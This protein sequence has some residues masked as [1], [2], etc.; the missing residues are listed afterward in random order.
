LRQADSNDLRDPTPVPDIFIHKKG[1][2]KMVDTKFYKC[3]HCGN[4]FGTIHDA[5]VVPICCGEKMEILVPN[6]T[7]AAQEKHVPVV[8]KNGNSVTV[9]VG[10]V[11][12]PMLAEHSIQWIIL[13]SGNATHRAVLSPGDAPEAVFTIADA[14]A[15]IKVLEYCNLHGLW[16]ADA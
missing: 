15:P 12:H 7:D 1:G 10:S 14:S 4:I 6:T 8:E 16:S 5:G 2:N 11:A 3:N 13:K 9:K